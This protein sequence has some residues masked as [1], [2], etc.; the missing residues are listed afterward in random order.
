MEE[1]IRDPD[2][3][4]FDTLIENNN[5]SDASLND[6]NM[7]DDIMKLVLNES[8]MEFEENEI[9]YQLQCINDIE[10]QDKYEKIIK[11]LQPVFQRLKYID[12]SN[13]YKLLI[14][15]HIK[16]ERIMNMEEKNKIKSILKRDN[17]ILLINKYIL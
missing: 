2:N 14:E 11:E 6:I 15:M 9:L 16:N 12:E 3:N 4:Y 1:Q 17:L 7:D 8:K 5:I 10:R 13:N